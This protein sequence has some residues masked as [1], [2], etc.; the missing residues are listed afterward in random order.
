MSPSFIPVAHMATFSSLFFHFTLLRIEPRALFFFL[1]GGVAL[2]LRALQ[3][4]SRQ[5][6]A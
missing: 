4:Q 5:F 2:E 1:L 3:L 6:T